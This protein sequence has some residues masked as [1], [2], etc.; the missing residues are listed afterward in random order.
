MNPYREDML[1]LQDSVLP[2][3]SIAEELRDALAGS[4]QFAMRYQPIIDGKSKKV[5]L[6]KALLRWTSPVLG[7][8]LPGRFIYI[9][10][11]NGMIRRV[12]QMVLNKVCEDISVHRDLMVSV[13]VSR[14]D[15]TDPDFAED[16][17]GI[18]ASHGIHPEQVILECS[19]S[20]TTEETSK[21]KATLEQLRCQGHSVAIYELES[22]FTSFGFLKMSGFTLLKIDRVLI[23]EAMQNA[24]SRENLQKAVTASK[25]KGFRALA[26][27]V[28]TAEQA[29]F[30]EKMGFDLQQGFFH[31]PSLSIDELIEYS[32]QRENWLTLADV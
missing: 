14:L 18:L 23:E 29:E 5:E 13:S 11:R 22:G 20:L 9:A 4:D 28:E 30:V 17:A 19:D 27:G 32:G 16:T 10:E 7:E 3:R 21:A 8:V 26:F 1:S 2:L 6:A 15:I 24:K 31:S 12:T 25:M